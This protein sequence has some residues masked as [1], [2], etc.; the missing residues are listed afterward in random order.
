LILSGVILFTDK[1]TSFSFKNN[2]GFEDS[3]TFVWV[4][5]QSL[6]PIILCLGGMLRPYKVFYH[7]PLYLYF[8]QIYWIF[9]PSIQFDDLLIHVYATGFCIGVFLFTIIA[10][11]FLKRIRNNNKRMLFN[12]RKMS[13][14]ILFEVRNK[15]VDSKDKK[16]FAK[17]VV[18][19][20]KTL[21]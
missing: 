17:D 13:T 8:I 14:F 15:Y 3:Q 20:N 18:D 19:L 9:D 1:L 11:V 5:C 10:I 16:A 21:K 6:S 7:I 2:Y 4:L 12:I